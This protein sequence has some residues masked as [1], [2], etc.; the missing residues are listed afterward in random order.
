MQLL[1]LVDGKSALTVQPPVVMFVALGLV[2]LPSSL[3]VRI[4]ET[5]GGS[6]KIRSNTTACDA[7]LYPPQDILTEP[8]HVYSS[9]VR[10]PRFSSMY[11]TVSFNEVTIFRS[12]SKLEICYLFI[13]QTIVILFVYKIIFM[14]KTSC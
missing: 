6:T 4:T 14:Q 12:T 5:V 8:T 7:V 9:V 3:Y 13:L 10:V 2:N 1:P 11:A